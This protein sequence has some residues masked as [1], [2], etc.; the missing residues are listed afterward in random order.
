MSKKKKGGLPSISRDVV[1]RRRRVEKDYISGLVSVT[2]LAI[3][4]GVSAPTISNDLKAIFNNWKEVYEQIDELSKP[5]DRTHAVLALTEVYRLAGEGFRRS[6]QN[7]QEVK[8]EYRKT[9]CED[10]GGTGWQGGSKSESGG[11]A[12]STCE[13]EGEVIQE[14]VTTRETGQAGDSSFLRVANDSIR[15]IARLKA[16]YPEKE[17]SGNSQ[18]DLNVY[19][20]GIDINAIPAEDIFAAKMLVAKLGRG[21]AR[22]V[23]EGSSTELGGS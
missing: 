16:L 21:G 8:T 15:E 23:I 14:L 5:T 4:H 10:C 9:K 17:R 1:E 7:K 3:R 19:N 20:L 22:K 13:G 18:I 2:D 6:Q 12:C 11:K